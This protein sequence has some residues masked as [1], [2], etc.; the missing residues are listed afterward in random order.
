ML[1]A[2]KRHRISCRFDQY[3]R[4]A[5]WKTALSGSFR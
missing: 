2:E 5:G 4:A 1:K 3:D